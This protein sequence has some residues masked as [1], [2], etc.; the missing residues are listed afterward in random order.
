MADQASLGQRAASLLARY[1]ETT[2][3]LLA[4]ALDR[5]GAIALANPAAAAWLKVGADELTGQP[6]WRWLAESDAEALRRRLADPAGPGAEPLRL[7][8]LDAERAPVELSCLLDRQSD[9][10]LL[11][12]EPVEPDGAA[13]RP[14]LGR[15]R[16]EVASLTRELAQQRRQIGRDAELLQKRV[17][18]RTGELSGANTRLR[19]EL[20][21]RAQAEADLRRSNTDLEQFAYVASHDL[22]EPLRMVVS[23][24]QLIERRYK[25]QLDQSGQEF[26]AYAVDGGKR[27]QV[28]INDLLAYSRV[29][30]GAAELAPTDLDVVL[31]RARRRLETAIVESEA[32]VT[33]E[34]LPSVLADAAQ[35]EQLFQ[36][37]L[38]NALKF[39][40]PERPRVHVSAERVGDRWRIGV[41]DNGI[42]IAPEFGERIF[43]LFQRLH[44]R[45][46]YEGTGIGLAV[47]RKIVDRHGGEIWV[48][49][50]R[51]QGATFYFTLPDRSEPVG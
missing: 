37:L 18:E 31:A 32:E 50:T 48:E 8:F 39:R 4:I 42:G 24:L 47:A 3:T 26:I 5:S 19:R 12:G 44:G 21:A 2:G 17:D 9:G 51:G 10:L 15:L 35:M 11:L 36:N 20:D 28:L 33:S 49:S 40:R 46:D 1:L 45:E 41:R 14:A 22:Q 6:I 29:G 38:A 7:T 23:Y 30:R 43:Q 16:A 13:G 34:P 25:S 27:M